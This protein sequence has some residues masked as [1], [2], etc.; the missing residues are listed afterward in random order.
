MYIEEDL[1][2]VLK[3]NNPRIKSY[4]N[5]LC[6]AGGACADFFIGG[7]DSRSSG[8]SRGNANYTLKT[9]KDGFQAPKASAC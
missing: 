3:R 4:V 5:H 8:K 7:V 6:M 1:Q 9:V 2:K